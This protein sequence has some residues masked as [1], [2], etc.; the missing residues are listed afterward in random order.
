MLIAQNRHLSRRTA[1]TRLGFGGLA[2]FISI[3]TASPAVAQ[4]ASLAATP[5]AIPPLLAEWAA[6]WSSHN[7]ERL[8][9]LYA[10]DAVYE[11]IPT[12]SIARGHE[13]IRTFVADSHAAF[14]NIQ[15][16]PRVGFQAEGWAVL[17][18]DFSAQSAEGKPISVPFAVVLE[19]EGDTIRRSADYFDLNAVLTQ[20]EA[21]EEP[22][23][24]AA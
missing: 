1:V 22:A 19:L 8:V 16:T 7:P 20:M 24:P 23:T 13:E 10:P 17:E 9:V 6:A 2:A 11:E 15:V 21:T 18:G 14:A 3:R 12:G 5:Q 4:D